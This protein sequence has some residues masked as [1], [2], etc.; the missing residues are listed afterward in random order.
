MAG[1]G[2]EGHRAR[3]VSVQDANDELVLATDPALAGVSGA[4]FVSKSRWPAPEVALQSQA[5]LRLWSILEQQ[6]GVK[7]P[8]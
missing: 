3:G 7:F 5:Q 4:Y 6:A 1:T 2:H 8:V